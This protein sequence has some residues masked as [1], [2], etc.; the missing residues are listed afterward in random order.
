MG[1]FRDGC[2]QEFV[3][4]QMGMFRNVVLSEICVFRVQKVV[5]PET[6]MLVH[7][8][9]FELGMVRSAMFTNEY[10]RK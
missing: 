9:L 2:V 7:V 1:M 6:G 5:Y 3:F 10:L 8:H 4:S